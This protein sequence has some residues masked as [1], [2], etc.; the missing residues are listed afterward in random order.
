MRGALFRAW[1]VF[2]AVAFVCVLVQL[3]PLWVE[4]QEAASWGVAGGLVRDRALEAWQ[5][6]CLYVHVLTYHVG[7]VVGSVTGGGK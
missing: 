7:V 6:V 2:L 4:V 3:Q 5:W 1:L